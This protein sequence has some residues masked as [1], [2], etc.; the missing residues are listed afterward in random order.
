LSGLE[1]TA[2]YGP[3]GNTDCSIEIDS[4]FQENVKDAAG[5]H[6]SHRAALH[7]ESRLQA[8]LPPLEDSFRFPFEIISGNKTVK[9]PMIL[10]LNTVVE[11]GFSMAVRI[12]HL[13]HT[14][15]FREPGKRALIFKNIRGRIMQEHQIFPISG[16]SCILK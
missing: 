8:I 7:D 11:P 15:F 14:K 10:S 16:G 12:N 2:K 6:P 3:C 1:V 9:R 13:F 5:E 4:V